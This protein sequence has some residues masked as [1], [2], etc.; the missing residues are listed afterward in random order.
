ML[1]VAHRVLLCIEYIFLPHTSTCKML[2]QS[3]LNIV[4]CDGTVII[5]YFSSE[6]LFCVDSSVGRVTALLA[7]WSGV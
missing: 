2:Q 3:K 7:G 5:Y 1:G 6:G 4:V